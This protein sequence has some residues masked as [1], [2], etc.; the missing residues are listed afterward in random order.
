MVDSASRVSGSGRTPHE[1]W[2]LSGN[3]PEVLRLM[4]FS[5]S[6]IGSFDSLSR[7]SRTPRT[8]R[9]GLTQLYFDGW[10]ALLALD[11]HP[12]PR[13]PEAMALRLRA[14]EL[15]AGLDAWTGG[16]LSRA[17][18]GVEGYH[19]GDPVIFTR[20]WILARD[21]RICSLLYSHWVGPWPAESDVRLWPS[22][23][24]EQLMNR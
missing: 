24:S 1:R 20:G 7:H 4:R 15:A 2:A 12:D 5:S 13:S 22:F 23:P 21:E 14:E 17:L 6:S 16:W 19:E 8:D 9:A 18:A 11:S 3:P 10:R